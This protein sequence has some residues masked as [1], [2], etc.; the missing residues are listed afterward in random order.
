MNQAKED[1]QLIR[2]M[3]ER[4]SS[5]LS[6]SGLSGV[7]AGT[8]ALVASGMAWYIMDLHNLDYFDGK[9]N[10]FP[11]EF[12][13]QLMIIA[14]SAL[15]FAFLFAYYFTYSKSRR[16]QIPIWNKTTQYFFTQLLIPLITGGLLCLILMYYGLYFL[17]AP[18]SLLFY[19]LSLISAS[20]YTQIDI[21]WLGVTELVLSFL[22]YI[23]PGFGLILWAFGF[24][25]LHIIYGI[26]MHYKYK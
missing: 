14:L 3:M 17:I 21:F 2:Q 6:L 13:R 15:V 12:T 8:V 18:T 16:L 25:V 1:I 10:E 11:F 7:A 4:S 26:L 20:K 22:G 5:F 19:G 23:I 9:R 24:G